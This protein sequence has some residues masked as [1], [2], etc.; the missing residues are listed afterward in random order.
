MEGV[1]VFRQRVFSTTLN[2]MFV[3]LFALL[4]FVSCDSKDRTQNANN[5]VI[6][7]YI[8]VVENVNGYGVAYTEDCHTMLY[9]RD[10][11][12]NYIVYYTKSDERMAKKGHEKIADNIVRIEMN[13]S[14][15]SLISILSIHGGAFCKMNNS[16]EYDVFYFDEQMI[17]YSLKQPDISHNSILPENEEKE[18]EIKQI[19]ILL[20]LA[21][22]VALS[23][24]NENAC[25]WNYIVSALEP[26]LEIMNY[27]VLTNDTIYDRK[28]K[29]QIPKILNATEGLTN[30]CYFL[31]GKLNSQNRK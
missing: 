11:I 9:R 25:G 31:R 18:N 7:K 2:V 16:Q 3:I 15:K 24:N 19:L 21:Y 22:E 4:Q 20:N 12:D 1:P 23:I 13:S 17:G 5:N 14:L 30:H 29:S 6:L 26:S 8:Y 27:E 28:I 10:S